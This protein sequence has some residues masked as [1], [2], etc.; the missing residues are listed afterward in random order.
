MCLTDSAICRIFFSETRQKADF[1]TMTYE[2]QIN[3]KLIALAAAGAALL[4]MTLDEALLRP[5]VKPV[6]KPVEK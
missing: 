1:N 2:L 3:P 5:V 6:V 4:G